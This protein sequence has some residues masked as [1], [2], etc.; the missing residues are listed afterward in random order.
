[1]KLEKEIKQKKFKNE[2]QKLALNII[3]TGNWLNS[4]SIKTFKPF[5]ISPQ[6]YNVLRILKGQYPDAISVNCIAERML[7]KNSNASRLVDKL[8]TKGLIKRETCEHDRRQVDIAITEKG[9]KLLGQMEGISNEIDAKIK[10]NL[11]D[12]EAKQL[13]DFLDRIRD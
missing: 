12:V 6:Q 11:S 9:I 8:N 3:F 10:A 5:G 7:D 1:M 2:F 13:N 4:N